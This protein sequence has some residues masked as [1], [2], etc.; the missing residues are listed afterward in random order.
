MPTVIAIAGATAAAVGTGVQVAGAVGAA[1]AA[2]EAA[3]AE[4]RRLQAQEE[5]AR[6][7]REQA[8]V[9]RQEAIVAAEPTSQEL[10]LQEKNLA[11][12][13]RAIARA[14]KRFQA[15][16]PAIIE[17]GQQAHS[18][19]KG[20]EAA[21]LQPIRRNRERQR[22]QLESNLRQQLGSGYASSTAGIEALGRFDERT[23][24]F[25]LQAQSQ[26]L[27]QS[28]DVARGLT[29]ARPSELALAQ[30][31]SLNMA[32]LNRIQSRRVSARLAKVPSVTKFAGGA[33]A[34]EAAIARGEQAK[35]RA[36]GEIGGA[37]GSL[38]GVATGF[39]AGQRKE[40]LEERRVSALE[41]FSQ[42]SFGDVASLSG[43]F[44]P[45]F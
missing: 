32:A 35:F 1:G 42:K 4:A 43:S 40:A 19:L 45:G 22:R 33:A 3:E 11:F 34:G 7:E 39:V 21:I 13:E 38:G 6:L 23:G 20:K 25:M 37:V 31:G 41:R 5:Q 14:E 15:I 29:A 26:A 17:A 10:A 44:G 8:E 28:V 2:G 12:Q 30:M 24:D 9:R 27:G 18:L 36:I 16:D